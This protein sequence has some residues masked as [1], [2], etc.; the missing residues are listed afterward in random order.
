MLAVTVS[1]LTNIEAGIQACAET[2]FRAVFIWKLGFGL[3]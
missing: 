1:C 2:N 3:G